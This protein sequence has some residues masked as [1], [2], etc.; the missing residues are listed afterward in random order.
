MGASRGA[1]LKCQGNLHQQKCLC[2]CPDPCSQ[3]GGVT[4][5]NRVADPTLAEDEEEVTAQLV[6]VQSWGY[7][8]APR[9]QGEE[10]HVWHT[11]VSH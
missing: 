7:H 4:S 2:P 5:Q 8:R 10:L 6:A 9:V 1:E 11:C 3:Q